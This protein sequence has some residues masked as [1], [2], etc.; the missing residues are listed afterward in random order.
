MSMYRLL[1]CIVEHIEENIKS[2]QQIAAIADT[3]N[4]SV[5][6][7]QRIFKF[8]FGMPIIKYIRQRKLTRSA[9]DLLKTHLKVI[10]IACEYGFEH[11]QSYIRAFKREYGITPGEF[12]RGTRF[13]NA[14][15]PLS[16]LNMKELDSGIVC[17][18]EIVI[19]PAFFV[20]GRRH[21]IALD[22]SITE[23]PRLAKE[24]FFRDK[25]QLDGVVNPHIYFG[26]TDKQNTPEGY[27][28]YL[29]SVQTV[30]LT[31]IPEGFTGVRV[32]SSMCVRFIY[33]G[34]HHYSDINLGIANEM[35]SSIRQFFISQPRFKAHD[36][37]HFERID[38]R[39]NDD[40]YCIMEWLTPFDEA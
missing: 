1:L 34:N 12:R 6:H 27:T 26:L 31:K 37:F 8:A 16:M 36:T 32:D 29:P 10:D 40:N 9:E 20:V 33:I 11:E 25:G 18:P 21:K 19:V 15:P 7:L 28:Y 30:D 4:I 23:A 35:Y 39:I 38:T 17:K 24:F 13:L 5:V 3:F 2:V 14:T 22:K